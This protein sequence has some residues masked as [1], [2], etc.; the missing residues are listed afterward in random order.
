MLGGST[1]KSSPAV[2]IISGYLLS[3][4]TSRE[5]REAIIFVAA[6]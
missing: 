1:P 3:E 2:D 5:R 6:A 4:R